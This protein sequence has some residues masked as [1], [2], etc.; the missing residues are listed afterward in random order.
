MAILFGKSN[1][2]NEKQ[3]GSSSPSK[4][5]TEVF[6]N[7]LF[8]RRRRFISF[9]LFIYFFLREVNF[10]TF[11]IFKNGNNHTRTYLRVFAKQR[12]SVMEKLSEGRS[13]QQRVGL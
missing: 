7:S 5:R 12:K 6:K 3:T 9:Y 10:F 11:D 4:A 1:L 8:Y 13:Y 2:E